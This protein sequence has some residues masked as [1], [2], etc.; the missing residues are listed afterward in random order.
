[1]KAQI[2]LRPYG[3]RALGELDVPV[4]HPAAVRV[5]QRVRHLPG[6]AHRL[7][8]AQLRLRFSLSRSVYP[9]TYGIT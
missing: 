5:V 2:L 8:H 4:D 1:M 7:L 6:D 9:S 3:L